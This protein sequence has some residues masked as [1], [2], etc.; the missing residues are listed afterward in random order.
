[1]VRSFSISAPSKSIS[2]RSENS[3]KLPLKNS[4]FSS[5]PK[6]MQKTHVR[7]QFS[8][9]FFFQ[10]FYFRESNSPDA[11]KVGVTQCLVDLLHQLRQILIFFSRFSKILPF[12][13]KDEKSLFYSEADFDRCLCHHGPKKFHIEQ[14][15]IRY[16]AQNVF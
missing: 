5:Y 7:I 16:L 14:P 10:P 15:I 8:S 12:L 4:F 6:I 11:H 13:A 9:V 3:M 2:F 1:M